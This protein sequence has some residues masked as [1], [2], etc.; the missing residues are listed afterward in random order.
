MILSK[1]Y[2]GYCKFRIKYHISELSELEL[3]NAKMFITQALL[4]QTIVQVINNHDKMR[5]VRLQR[6]AQKAMERKQTLV[7]RKQE[8]KINRDGKLEQRS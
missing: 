5:R 7:L 8:G 6:H 1:Y 3:H 4:N 2:C